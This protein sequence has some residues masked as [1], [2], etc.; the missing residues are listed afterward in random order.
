M[1]L[2]NEVWEKKVS[3]GEQA[4]EGLLGLVKGIDWGG[5]RSPAPNTLPTGWEAFHLDADSKL[6][7]DSTWKPGIN[8]E[9]SNTIK[10]DLVFRASWRT[11]KQFFFRVTDTAGAE[12]CALGKNFKMYYFA[13]GRSCTRD[14]ATLNPTDST[15]VI[16]FKPVFENGS[17]RLDPI[18]V[19]KSMFTIGGMTGIFRAIVDAIVN[20]IKG[21]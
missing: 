2:Y 5:E 3:Y 11:Y 20:A 19:P 16:L 12:Y 18:S 7:D 17:L 9:D 6:D 8:A 4:D 1:G 21:V 13:N 10:S 14:M 15:I